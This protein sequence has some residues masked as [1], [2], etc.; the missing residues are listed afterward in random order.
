MED[1]T[2]WCRGYNEQESEQTYGAQLRS[3]HRWGMRRRL[4][5]EAHRALCHVR[6]WTGGGM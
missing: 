3:D 1:W 6:E 2:T 5:V 4:A